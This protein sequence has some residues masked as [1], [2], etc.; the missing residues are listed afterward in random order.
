LPK[1]DK[2]LILCIDG[3]NDIGI[4]AKVVTPIVGRQTNLE[5]A[6]IL[7][8]SD[9]EEADANAMFGAIKLYDQLLGQYPDESF[10]VATI[11]GSSMGGVEADR[12]MVK[13]LSEFSKPTKPTELYWLQMAS[14]TRNWYR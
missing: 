12:K 7:A 11:A 2:T 5:S 6:T 4:K 3:D 8:V 9:P 14:R 1:T 13:E 10:E